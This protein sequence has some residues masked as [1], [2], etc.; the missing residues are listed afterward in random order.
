MVDEVFPVPA[1]PEPNNQL[2]KYRIAMVID[3]VV[4]QVMSLEAPDAARYLSAPTFIQIPKSLHV[5]PGDHHDGT[6][7]ISQADF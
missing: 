2:G 5:A 1:L 4:H 6:N 7:F 3:N